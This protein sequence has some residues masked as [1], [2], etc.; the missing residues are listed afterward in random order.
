MNLK[1]RD[2][3]VIDTAT[4]LDMLRAKYGTDYQTSK[5]LGK[6]PSFVSHLRSRHGVLTD[7]QGLKAAE[8]LDFPEDAILL[9][10]AAERALNSPVWEKIARV[11]QAHTPKELPPTEAPA[12]SRPHKKAG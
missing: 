12:P 4:I 7:E 5:A 10:L 2:Q 9:S 1:S 11:A 6:N 3:P 8:L